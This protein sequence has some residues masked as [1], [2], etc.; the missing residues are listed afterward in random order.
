MNRLLR[1]SEVNGLEGL[2]IKRDSHLNISGRSKDAFKLKNIL[3]ADLRVVSIKGN[4]LTLEDDNHIQAKVKVGAFILEDIKVNNI[5]EVS[6]EFICKKYNG[7]K[8]ISL[9]LDKELNNGTN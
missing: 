6:Y 7:T 2:F 8:F 5:V 9:R 3:T 4:Y 1:L